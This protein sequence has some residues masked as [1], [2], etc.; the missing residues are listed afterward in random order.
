MVFKT[1]NFEGFAALRRDEEPVE[2]AKDRDEKFDDK[3]KVVPGAG[4]VL[5]EG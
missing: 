2:I 5:Q 4:R 1:E 3:V